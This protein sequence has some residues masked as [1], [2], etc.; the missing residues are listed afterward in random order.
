MG[1]ESHQVRAYVRDLF[2]EPFAVR[3]SV[4]RLRALPVRKQR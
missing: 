1:M 2:S 4:T 3:G